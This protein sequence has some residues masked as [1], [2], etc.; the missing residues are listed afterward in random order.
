MPKFSLEERIE[1]S[2]ARSKQNVFFRKDFVK[3]GGYDQVGRALRSVVLKGLL[4]KAGYGIYA[5]AKTSSLTGN[6]IPVIPLIQIGLEALLKMGVDA[7]LGSSAKEYMAGKTTQMPMK[8]VVN[9]GNAR[10]ARVI[11][12]GGKKVRYEKS[13]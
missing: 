12:F 5:K 13:N 4:V 2:V 9:I 6:P 11:G 3:F 8:T 10:I 7:E 1:M